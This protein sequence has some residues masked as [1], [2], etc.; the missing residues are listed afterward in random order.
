M[1]NFPKHLSKCFRRYPGVHGH[2]QTGA[3]A[4][5][6]ARA[7]ERDAGRREELVLSFCV[8]LIE[9]RKKLDGRWNKKRIV[10]ALMTIKGILAEEAQM[11]RDFAPVLLVIAAHPSRSAC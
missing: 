8:R 11:N 6:A 2:D 1:K 10:T 4:L 7:L 9:S 5:S 3:E